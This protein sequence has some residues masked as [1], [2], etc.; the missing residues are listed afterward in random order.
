MKRGTLL[1]AA[2]LLAA[3]SHDIQNKEAVRQGV[4]D[5]LNAR[6]GQTGL[7]M[8]VLQVDVAAVTFTGDEARATVSFR[9]RSGGEGGMQMRYTLNRSGNRWVVRG[10]QENGVNP[11]GGSMAVPDAGA[12]PPGHPPVGSTK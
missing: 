9:P 3:C 10:R 4:I 1:A 5:Y 8:N 11:H 7:D 12:L 6:K 2:A